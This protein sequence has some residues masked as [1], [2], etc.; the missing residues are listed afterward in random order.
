M[1][2][3]FSQAFESVSVNGKKVPAKQYLTAGELPIIDQGQSFIGGYTNDL[4]LA[5]DPEDGLIVF[6]DHT[7]VFK[8]VTFQFAPGAD[9]IKVLKPN[10]CSPEYAHYACLSLQFPDKG[11]SRH[12]SY[13][14]KCK[15]PLAPE[16]EQKRIVSKLDELFSRIDE[17]ERALEQVSKLVERYRQS[18][19]K[20]A[21]TGE[22]TRDWRAA[23]KA[24]GEPVESGEALLTRI[25]TARREAWE[26]AELAKLKAKG[27]KPANDHWKK[28][29]AEPASP[30][31]TDLPELPEGWVWASLPLLCGI[32]STNGIS[33]KGSNTPPGVPALRLDAMGLSGFDYN[34]RRYIP[35]DQKRAQRLFIHT[36]DFFVSRANGSLALVGRAVLPQEP[37]DRIVFPDTMI[38][39]RP[40]DAPDCRAWLASIWGSRFVREQIE[41]K[42][43]TTAGIYKIS[44]EDISEIVIPV[45]PVDEQVAVISLIDERLSQACGA[46]ASTRSSGKAALAMKQAILK[47]AF[48]GQLI[49][50]DPAD[51]PATALL[52]RI[53]A[54][55]TAPGT[56][57]PGRGR[58][59]KPA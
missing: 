19:L 20:A 56:A 25:L 34:A 6:G 43:K 18:V 51:E 33:V 36:G 48:S 16:R 47:Q 42:A 54:E 57:A 22:L 8:R 4:N 17:G 14:S 46:D 7:R 53:A 35:I 11:Y 28:K 31:T 21:V 5:I 12:F 44:Q 49:P 38:R 2:V 23:R 55:R 39:Y 59:R 45:P 1:N 37:P 10:F 41:R 50:Q 13:L 40:I 3:E 58:R 15:F 24:R 26:Q 27:I 52:E 30:D 9:G 32:N 29:Y